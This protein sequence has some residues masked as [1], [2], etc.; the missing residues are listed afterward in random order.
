MNR[1]SIKFRLAVWYAGLLAVLLVVFAGATYVAFSN[2]LREELGWSLATQARDIEQGLL[3]NVKET[4]EAYVVRGIQEHYAP[5]TNGLFL[6]ITRADGSLLY[7]SGPPRDGAFDPAKVIAKMITAGRESASEIKLENGPR[8]LVYSMPVTA[9]DGSHFLIE[10]G[11]TFKEIDHKSH[12]LLISQAI[13]VPFVLLLTTVGGWLL[14][15]RAL[16]PIDAI[17]KGAERITSQNL[18]ERL[19][20]TENGDELA[21]LAS[22]LNQMIV[23]LEKGFE[24]SNRFSADAS[25]EL[26]TP[27]AILRGEL[28]TVVAKPNLPV[29]VEENVNSALEET[30][31]LA[32]MTENLLA[33][34]RL[35]NGDLELEKTRF[36]LTELVTSTIDLMK[37]VA[38]DKKIAL[39]SK[40]SAP[41]LVEGSATRLNQVVVNL[42]DNAI[43]YTPEGGE[44]CVTVAQ[45][46]D[47]ALLEVSDN[48]IGIPAESLTQVFERFYRVD[49]TRTRSP[50][51]SGLGLSIVKSICTAHGG[52][53]TV[54][55]RN[56]RG[57]R[58]TVALPL[59][60]PPR[61]KE[62]SLPSL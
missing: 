28:E 5:E 31:R 6:R 59:N 52:D 9:L 54:E 27:L 30:D 53:V 45:R 23:R 25:H 3:A 29:S 55:S 16:K 39:L 35:E 56:G 32:K 10:V 24:H 8:L 15:Q 18:K 2:H 4:G 57:S 34:A 44:V 49:R 41:V 12:A 22:T 58:F 17:I 46:A 33:M 19:P 11:K 14:M 7:A 42:L 40:H 38:D 36:D 26:R 50:Q 37:P 60:V 20:V 47:Q 1:R 13:A 61:V 43:K 51:G 21:R 48:G 62:K